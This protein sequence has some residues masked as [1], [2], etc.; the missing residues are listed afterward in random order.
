MLAEHLLRARSPSFHH[1][2]STALAGSN[3]SCGSKSILLAESVRSISI[4]ADH[5][6][7]RD[8]DLL[9]PVIRRAEWNRA[10]D[11]KNRPNWPMV[12]ISLGYCEDALAQVEEVVLGLQD[13]AQRLPF[14][15]IGLS[16]HRSRPEPPGDWLGFLELHLVNGAQSLTFLAQWRTDNDLAARLCLAFAQ[17]EAAMQPIRRTGW[18]ERYRADLS[19]ERVGIL[20]DWDGSI[21]EPPATV[22]NT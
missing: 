6:M 12:D 16:T 15:A 10:L 1:A 17:L 19:S 13:S 4:F 5:T 11:K 14:V 7:N 20:W 2:E 8:E 21:P 3:R 9:Q 22:M 18:L